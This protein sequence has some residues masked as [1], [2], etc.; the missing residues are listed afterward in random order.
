MSASPPP[1]LPPQPPRVPDYASPALHPAEREPG[2]AQRVFDTVAG[3]NLRL[4][5]NLVQLLCVI[6]GTVAGAIIG[7]ALET[8]SAPFPM[9]LLGALGG[10]IA[11]ALL[12]GLIIGIVRMRRPSKSR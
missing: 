1:P 8:P 2:G 6:V 9:M 5:D 4:R 7:W 3:P 10:L 12:S 11:S